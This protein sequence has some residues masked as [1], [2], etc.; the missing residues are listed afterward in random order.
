[1]FSSLLS[2]LLT[3]NTVQETQET[4]VTEKQEEINKQI[5][6]EK[7]RSSASNCQNSG[8]ASWYGPGFHGKKTASGQRFNQWSFTAAHRS[9]PFGT[10]LLVTN[11]RNG[12]SV[13]VTINDRGPYSGNRSLDL[14]RAAMNK[15]NGIN[16]GVINV[17]YRRI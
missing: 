1:M 17:C 16:A 11:R 10:K 13:I 9:L 6:T 2:L 5:E 15:L 12:K 3:S 8:R 7:H 14:S 4:L